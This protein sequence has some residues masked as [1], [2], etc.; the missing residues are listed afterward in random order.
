MPLC[1]AKFCTAK[2]GKGIICF[3]IPDPTKSR[4]LCGKWIH[5][6]GIK[7]LVIKTFTY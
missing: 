5:N 6:L 1:K 2:R 3:A 7:N 4:T